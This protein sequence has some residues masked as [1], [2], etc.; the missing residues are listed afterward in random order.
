MRKGPRKRWARESQPSRDSEEA[1]R[2]LYAQESSA[3]WL[4]RE[5]QRANLHLRPSLGGRDQSPAE[6]S[7]KRFLEWVIGAAYRKLRHWLLVYRLM[8]FPLSPK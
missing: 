2:L 6:I 8:L 5:K 4:R 3:R 1:N 7:K